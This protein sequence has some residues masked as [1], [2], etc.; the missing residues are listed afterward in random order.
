MI[1]SERG[2]Y[3]LPWTAYLVERAHQQRKLQREY[4]EYCNECD[5]KAAAVYTRSAFEKI[6]RKHCEAKKK[7]IP[8]KAK[9]KDY[10]TEDFWCVVKEDVA[11]SI[12][13]EIEKYRALVL[14]PF[15]HYNT[16]RHEIKTEL[17]DAIEA[18][19]N[20]NNELSKQS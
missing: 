16:E 1:L 15:S 4:E 5:Y 8:F 11:S 3:I 10:T 6:L 20:L 7:K 14:N 18:V 17:K 9:L 12:Q 19:K 2:N 13:S